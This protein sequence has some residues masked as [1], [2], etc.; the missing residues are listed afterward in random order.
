MKNQFFV[1]MTDTFGGEANYSWV[2]R[3]L[4]SASSELGAIR[5]VTRR[6]G[7]PARSVGCDRYNVPGACIRYFVEWVDPEMVQSMKD[8]YS[9]I[10][11][12]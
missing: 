4:V 10:E 11:V 5:K 2:N 8:N 3:F 1:E 6:T 12:F 7:Y 9:R